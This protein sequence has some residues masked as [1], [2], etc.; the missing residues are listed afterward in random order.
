MEYKT[1]LDKKETHRFSRQLI[2]KE[3]GLENHKRICAA[4][5]LIVGL[6]GLG[7]PVLTYLSSSGIKN[8]ILVD[9]DTVELHNLQRQTIHK[10]KFINELKTVS[11]KEFIK[12]IN[13]SINVEC[14]ATKLNRDN[15]NL[16]ASQA[17]IIVDCTDDLET[18]YI[19]SEYAKSYKKSVIMGSVLKFSGQVYV[20]PEGKSCYSCVFPEFKVTRENCSNAGVLGSVCGI[21]GSIQATEVIK[22]IL[23]DYDPYIL[24]YDAIDNAFNKIS[25]RKCKNT[26][27]M[28]TFPVTCNIEPTIPSE[29]FL[30]W[31]DYLHD[32]EKYLLVDLRNKEAYELCHLIDS[33]NF[34]VD[35][36]SPEIDDKI[37]VLLCRRGIYAQ[38]VWDQFKRKNI[39]VLK[40]GL[41][42]YKEEVDPNFII[43]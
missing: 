41:T 40:G 24:T 11:A 14:Y 9:F 32:K 5:I 33:V 13:S 23:N 25:I 36:I 18:R 21:I 17:N 26:C 2:L 3:I 15:I 37:V 1:A 22:N 42:A 19:I 16:I 20:F 35:S 38:K 30:T 27:N 28:V 12:E 6:G 39:F 43:F 34:S 7:S 10:E 4:K 8:F 29:N 31:K